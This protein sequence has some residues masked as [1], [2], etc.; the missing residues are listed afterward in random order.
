MVSSVGQAS[1]TPARLEKRKESIHTSSLKGADALYFE[2]DFLSGLE[3][4]RFCFG[5][6][7][8]L[9]IFFR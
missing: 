3:N 7:G 5:L 2:K 6:S 9:I 8:Q 1:T 4:C